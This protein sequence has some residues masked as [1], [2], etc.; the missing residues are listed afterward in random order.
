M[1]VFK[2]ILFIVPAVALAVFL[3]YWA[4]N[5]DV[6]LWTNGFSDPQTVYTGI[7]DNGE[8]MQI[9]KKEGE[10]GFRLAHLTKSGAGFW[11]LEYTA[12]P[13]GEGYTV[14]AW[15]KWTGLRTFGSAQNGFTRE[16]H[17]VLCGKNAVGTIAIPDAEIPNNV[18][19]GVEQGSETYQLHVISYGDIS[20]YQGELY[21]YLLA[22]NMVA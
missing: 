13:V 12:E 14:M 6:L 16:E 3:L 19:V 11:R 2:R 10:D 22:N 15:G 20:R 7:D 17:L 1:K 21:D 5:Y 18:T 9:L 4:L 8:E